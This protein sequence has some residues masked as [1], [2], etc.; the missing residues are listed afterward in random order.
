MKENLKKCKKNLLLISLI[1]FLNN[2]NLYNV[3]AILY[4]KSITN[5]F[6]LGMSIF[7]ITTISS[8]IFE[9]PTGIISDK[10]GR[11]KTIVYGSSCSVL[12][13]IILFLANNYYLLILFAIINGIEMAFFSGNNDAYVYDNLCMINNKEK[14]INS[15]GKVKSMEYL[16]GAISGLIGAGLLYCFSYKLIIG[17]SI[18]PKV[19]Q[20]VISL[21]L[22]A[23]KNNETNTNS[24]KKLIKGALKESLENKL[25]LKKVLY[26]GILQSTNESCYQ[27]RSAFYETVWPIWAIGIPGILSNIGA[28]I[29]NWCSEKLISKTSRKKYWFLSHSYSMFSNTIAVITNNIISPIIMISNSLFHSDFI[30]SEIE[31]KLYKDEYRASMG[32]IKSFIQSILFAVFSVILGLIA[33]Y[34]NIVT[35]F[36]IFQLINIIPIIMNSKI[37]ENV[38]K[39]YKN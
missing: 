37:I 2:I 25:L 39:N 21:F 11:K 24:N 3:V 36:I 14:Y 20:L 4:Y 29:S 15:I 32:S 31:Q 34:F 16:A 26:D 22:K 7:S 5:S 17:I 27:F 18:I 35:S 28:F 13:A 6:V 9:L 10:I 1:I 30:D 8:A 23:I 33:D 19:I 38:E 12:S